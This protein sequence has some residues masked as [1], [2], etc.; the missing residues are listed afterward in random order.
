MATNKHEVLYLLNK[1]LSTR[2]IA[3]AL[4]CTTS[5]VRAT[6]DRAENPDRYARYTREQYAKRRA[7]AHA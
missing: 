7:S 2:E 6:R 3:D 5:Y 1:G 4:G